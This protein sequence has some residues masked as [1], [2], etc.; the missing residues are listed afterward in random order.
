[1]GLSLN[2][3]RSVAVPMLPG[4]NRFFAAIIV[5][6][7]I[8]LLLTAIIVFFTWSE[9][10][11]GDKNGLLSE[12]AP[13]LVSDAILLL[14]VGFFGL[15]AQFDGS[16]GDVLRQRIR[17]L[18]S[19]KEISHSVMEFFEGVVQQNCV[20]AELAEHNITVLEFKED[21]SA[22]R[23]EHYNKYV[24]KNALGDVS[25]SSGFDVE[26]DPDIKRVINQKICELIEIS[27]TYGDV[28]K[29]VNGATEIAF[30]GF[31][32][33][34]EIEL[35]PGAAC[36]LEAKWWSWVDAN[37]G[38]S[39]YSLKRFSE[40][41]LVR[42]INKAH[43]SVRFGR[44]RGEALTELGYDNQ[45]LLYDVRNLLPRERREFFWAPPV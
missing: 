26:I 1:M 40:K 37:D 24:L 19:N 8:Y 18:F 29:Q 11:A 9:L 34:V 25:H 32:R 4:L 39:G 44:V 33:R 36:T 15:W 28:R 42:L 31:K 43:V 17:N 22:Y 27:V 30:E 2:L 16:K 13:N 5:G 7:V 6:T 20:Y 21:I 3:I 14:L 12:L 23:V 38:D 45:E 35:G 41:F 10:H